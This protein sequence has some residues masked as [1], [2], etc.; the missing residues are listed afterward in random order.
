MDTLLV[1]AD[2]LF[3]FEAGDARPCQR[4]HKSTD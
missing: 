4:V 2:G 3:F 1:L